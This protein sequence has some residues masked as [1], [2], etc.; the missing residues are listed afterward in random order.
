MSL[1]RERTAVAV[2]G[3]G[4]KDIRIEVILADCRGSLVRSDRGVVAVIGME[5]VM[6]IRDGDAVLVCP[7][8][9]SEEVKEIV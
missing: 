5:N 2:P 6:V 4:A 9:R 7:R 1:H 8:H 3:E